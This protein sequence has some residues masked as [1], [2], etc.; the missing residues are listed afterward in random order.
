MGRHGRICHYF[1]NCWS[2]DAESGLIWGDCSIFLGYRQLS[3]G[4]DA[5]SWIS[6]IADGWCECGLIDGESPLQYLDPLPGSEPLYSGEEN[7]I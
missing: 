5:V 2:D 7:R 3:T 1:G 4:L 6:K